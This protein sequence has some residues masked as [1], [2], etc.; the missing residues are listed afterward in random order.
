[1]C[2]SL[3][4]ISSP[5]LSLCFVYVC[6]YIL[7]KVSFCVWVLLCVLDYMFECVFVLF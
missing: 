5:Y 3:L 7:Q 4:I 2:L 6:V 1:M